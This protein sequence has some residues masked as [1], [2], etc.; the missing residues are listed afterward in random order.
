MFFNRLNSTAGIETD[1]VIFGVVGLRSGWQKNDIDSG[2]SLRQ[3]F[4]KKTYSPADLK[5]QQLLF[6]FVFFGSIESE[7]WHEHVE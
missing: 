5:K 4:I 1:D 6:F 7:I 2:N 3:L